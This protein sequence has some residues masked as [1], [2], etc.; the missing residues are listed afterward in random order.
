AALVADGGRVD[1]IQVARAS[2]S[3]APRDFIELT[4]SWAYQERESNRAL[5]GYDAQVVGMEVRAAF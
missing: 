5:H 1:E 3:Y 2:A 4:L